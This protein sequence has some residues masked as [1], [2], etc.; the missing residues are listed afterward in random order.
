MQFVHFCNIFFAFET[1]NL[2][3]TDQTTNAVRAIIRMQMIGKSN[4]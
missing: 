2:I 4:S 3:P 1:E